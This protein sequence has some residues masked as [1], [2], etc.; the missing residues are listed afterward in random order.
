MRDPLGTPCTDSQGPKTRTS[1]KLLISERFPNATAH[2]G[3]GTRINYILPGSLAPAFS[4]QGNVVHLYR[5]SFLPEAI[6]LARAYEIANPGQELI[7]NLP[8]EMPPAGRSTINFTELGARNTAPRH[9]H[10]R[11]Q[12][13]S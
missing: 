6:K 1:I 12:P 13:F 11:E 10:Y 8:P 7:I 2:N 4:S 3:N 5:E 9:A